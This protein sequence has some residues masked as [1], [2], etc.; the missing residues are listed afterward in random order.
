MIWQKHSQ[1]HHPNMFIYS[2]IIDYFVYSDSIEQYFI[3]LFYVI[4]FDHFLNFV[5]FNLFFLGHFNY[6]GLLGPIHM[7]LIGFYCTL[8]SVNINNFLFSLFL[9]ISQFRFFL[10]FL[11]VDFL[12]LQQCLYNNFI[13][14]IFFIKV[15]IIIHIPNL[16]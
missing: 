12:F 1:A 5:P 11:V 9:I 10:N 15:C 16:I 2:L 6:L 4:R 14:I 13:I 7:I 8:A 3:E